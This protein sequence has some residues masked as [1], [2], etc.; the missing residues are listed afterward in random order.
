MFCRQTVIVMQ[1]HKVVFIALGGKVSSL[2]VFIP[3]LRLQHITDTRVIQI[4]VAVIYA[5]VAHNVLLKVFPHSE[6]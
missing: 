1:N 4:T 3:I 2:A 6:S 5:V